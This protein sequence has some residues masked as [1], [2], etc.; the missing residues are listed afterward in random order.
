[1]AHDPQAAEA[2]MQR[3]LDQWEARRHRADEK[4]ITILDRKIDAAERLL[5]ALCREG[6][7]VLYINLQS[8]KGTPTG[9]TLEGSRTDLIAYLIRNRYV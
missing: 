3:R 5:G 2:D 6:K 8:R 4:A 7:T 1:M 9:R